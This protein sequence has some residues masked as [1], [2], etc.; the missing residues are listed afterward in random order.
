M[1]VL[2]TVESLPTSSTPYPCERLS[3][4]PSDSRDR[5]GNILDHA[6]PEALTNSFQT[7][8][9]LCTCCYALGE[10]LSHFVVVSF[11]L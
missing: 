7:F 2:V 3:V 5:T 10:L 8:V 9:Y 6:D 11:P 4:Q 1:A